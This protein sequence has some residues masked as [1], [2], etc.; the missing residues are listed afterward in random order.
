MNRRE[1][2]ERVAILT[3]AAVIG[4]EFFLA[5]CKRNPKQVNSLFNEDQVAFMNEVGD[6]ILPDTKTPGAKAADVGGFMAIMVQDCY[7]PED[8]QVFMKGL[9]TVDEETNK[10]FGKKFMDCDQKQRLELLTMLDQEQKK[11]DKQQPKPG[12]QYQYYAMLKQMTL[13]GYFTSEI[14][15][16]QALR[17]REVP[18]HYDGNLPYKKGD[19]AWAI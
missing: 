7:S 19:K 1:A 12:K 13:L 11:E 6:T 10:K 14:G 15:C 16:T 5:G 9:T 3:G 4:A 17:Y 2:I 8:Q 18:G